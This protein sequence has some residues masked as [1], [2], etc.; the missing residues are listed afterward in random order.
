M[1]A[2]LGAFVP[3]TAV[4][5][6]GVV[7]GEVARWMGV[8]AEAKK[9]VS[10]LDRVG[11]AV[12]DAEARAARGD[13]A[14]ARWL[15]NVRAVA[16]EADGAVDWCRVTARQL[17][18]VLPR[19]LS[20]CC[21]AD[22]PI[23]ANIKSLNRKLQVILKEK[24]KLQLRSSLGDHHH[25]P[26]RTVPRHRKSQQ[27]SRSPPN[28]DIIGAR[29]EDDTRQ[30]EQL[31]ME[32]DGQTSGG[33]IVAIT[34]PDG[35]GKTTLAAKVYCSERIRRSFETRAWVRIPKGHTRAGL[36]SQVIDSFGGYTKGSGSV[37]DLG[38]T[39]SRLVEKKRC[40]LVLDDVWYGGVWKE[41]FRSP[42]EHAGRGSKVLVTAR[43][44]SI[45]RE[46]GA[47]H[48]HRVKKLGADDGWLLLRAAAR[49]VDEAAAGE[50]ND[51]GKSIVEKCGGVP[52]AIKA[53]AGVLRTRAASA[54]EWA[55]VLKSP[56]WSVKGLPE[57]AMKSLYLC[58]DDLPCHLK[59]CFL[60]CSMFPSDL[61]VDRHDLVQQ[62][63]SEGFVQIRADASIEE[64]AE[65]YYD[66]LV[67]RHLLHKA[68]E[69][70]SGGATRCSMHDT[71]RALARILSQGEDLTGDAHRQAVDGDVRNPLTME[72]SIFT[73]LQHLRILD[74]SETAVDL[75]PENLGNLVYL[76]Y[77]NLSDT[78]IQAIPESIGNL[79]NLKFL[80]LRGCKSL[81]KLPKGIEHLRGLRDLDLAGTVIDDAAFTVGHLRSLTSLQCFAVTSKQ[82]RAAQDRS[83]W[84]LD[85][86]KHLSQLRILHITNLEKATGRSEA[87]EM[88]LATKKRLRELEMSCSSTA[89]TI[90]TVEGIRHFEDIFEEVNPPQCLESLKIANYFGTKFP[91][92]LSLTYL[93]NL[94]HLDIIG[95]DFCQSFPPLGRLPEL[96]SLYI[97]DSS[98]LKDIGAEFMGTDHQHQVVPFPKLENLHL[99]G[100]Y[101][102]KTWT[103]IEVGAFPSLQA[104]QLESCPELQHLPAGLRQV[105][106]L[107]ELRIV[108][109]ASLE[110]VED[111]SS[112][113]ELS[114]WNAP[115]L[116]SISNMS[117]LE[118]LN[119]C[120]CP[121]LQVVNIDELQTVHIFDHELRAMP[122]WI[123]TVASRLQSLNFTST[124]VLLKR[125]LV[126]GPD[127]PMIKD[128]KQVNGYSTGSSYIHYTKSPY[129]FESN[130]N[131]DIE[132]K[133]E[134][135]DDVDQCSVSSSDTGYQ[136]I[137]G[138]FDSK[139]VNTGTTRSKDNVKSN[140][141]DS[142]PSLTHRRLHK[143]AEVPE[144]DESYTD[145]K[146]V[147]P[148]F[149]DDNVKNNDLSSGSK[150][151]QI[152]RAVSITEIDKYLNSNT[153]GSKEHTSKK[154]EDTAVDVNVKSNTEDSIPRLTRRRLHKLVEVP[155][156]NEVEE[157]VH[158]AL[159]FP[160]NPISVTPAVEKVHPV[161]TD[162]H[163]KNNDLSSWLKAMQATD[164]D[165]TSHE[166]IGRSNFTNRRRFKTGKDAPSDDGTNA[167]PSA[168]KTTASISHKLVREGSRAVNVAEIDQ[169]LN[170]STDR[171][172]EHISE[173]EH[174]TVDVNIGKDISPAHSRSRQVSSKKGKVT[175]ADTR[176]ATVSSSNIVTQNHIKSQ[177]ATTPNESANATPTSEIPSGKD[178]PTISVGVTTSS[179]IHVT[180]QTVYVTETSQDLD[181]SLLC[182]EEQAS[183]N[184]AE[185]VARTICATRVVSNSFDQEEDAE[186][187]ET[188]CA[189]SAV[190]SSVD[191]EEDVEVTETIRV[192]SAVSSSVDQEEDVKA[193]ETVCATTAVSNSID[194][195]KDVEVAETI[196]AIN[197][198]SNSVDQEEDVRVAETICATST[199]SSSVDQ[200]DD[201]QVAETICA[202]SAI[203]VSNS[204]DQDEDG[205]VAE[206]ICAT[207]AITV[208]NSVDQREDV[209]ITSLIQEESKEISASE[210]NRDDLGACKLPASLVCSKQQTQN[211]LENV[212]VEASD[213]TDGSMKKI[214]GMASR[215]TEKLTNECEVGSVKDSPAETA[216]K[217]ARPAS[218]STR[219][220]SHVIITEAAPN[221]EVTTASRFAATAAAVKVNDCRI[222]DDDDDALR[223]TDAEAEDSYQAAP[224]VYTAMWADTDT[225][226]LRARFLE[227]MRQYRRMASRRRRRR[228]RK[229]GSG[230]R[231]W[232]VGPATVAAVLLV[233]SVAQL[234]FI[235]GMY[236]RL[237]SQN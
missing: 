225:D 123:E 119:M 212:S 236:R 15:A 219:T 157:G 208:S 202:T 48:V 159:R 233:F 93:P 76:K 180:S 63:I 11:A 152:L 2:V 162:D 17:K 161:F 92:W 124:V 90:Q 105:T 184:E 217:I 125:C 121:E 155:E 66:E 179:V 170:S 139:V 103:D 187:A 228:E 201:V 178:V 209:N 104:L 98:A 177:I 168:I 214:L 101:K 70:E 185:E 107:T 18:Q 164:D 31:L 140:T 237:T 158:S 26:V 68:E 64:V 4:R 200:E 29:M 148:V 88:A 206:I 7:T 213:D 19:L 41:I 195:E 62:W 227:S 85:E 232:S 77:L 160:S 79:W 193:T 207:S 83:G 112:L 14:A 198:V 60:Y 182:S 138:F 108:D 100:L 142:I 234:L 23:A 20:S 130:V 117:S 136:E 113:R 21:D 205:K 25:T 169:Y 91:R 141:E 144:E 35:I 145:M 135:P 72:G 191:K 37:A 131:I 87:A 163:T 43:H 8:A 126:D 32:K 235:F 73:R 210:S 42:M 81:H 194:Q 211:T 189:T 59:Q 5:W 127:W 134:D 190:S 188:T 156:E 33:T 13:E 69:D 78:R 52:L 203:T 229:H 36:L 172:K 196:Y 150:A 84:S 58:Y 154:G 82:A 57:D 67:G 115:K 116:K 137:Q 65:E 56:A 3:D 151:T 55:E 226:T 71:V 183:N 80:L 24:H 1:A 75:V 102:L 34:G 39:L 94:R 220:M 143:L 74:L 176:T 153:E 120:H 118:D 132:E 97:A 22:E 49:V 54:G 106:S 99:Q 204:V 129:M 128:I 110:A 46:M 50:L 221:P 28:S 9:L 114:V 61:G 89:R 186:V 47:G 147:R 175:F 16:Y 12:E 27:G 149:T 30:L 40:L 171:S 51:V 230:G 215:I 111:I 38:R 146:K 224:K 86:L 231:R 181:S 167:D 95:C 109:M 165:G 192:T 166:T 173:K 223:S 218:K 197:A 222:N 53:V 10:R 216:T 122:R 96:R 199:A 174:T 133:D 44:G 6:R 45:A